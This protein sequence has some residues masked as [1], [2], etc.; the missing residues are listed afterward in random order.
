MRNP[1][2][3]PGAAGLGPQLA[4]ANKDYTA[5]WRAVDT[6]LYDLCRRR[7]NN[8]SFGDVYAKVTIIGR[9]YAAGISR[10]SRASGDAEAEVTRGLISLADLIEQSLQ[11]LAGRQFDRATAARIVELHG[12]VAGGLLPY[13]GDTWQHS[14]V[15]KYLHFHCHL[16]PIYDSN[17]ERAVGGFVD[18][19]DVAPVRALMPDLPDSARAYRNFV[20]AFVVLRERISAETSI[21]AS[22]KEIDHLLWHSA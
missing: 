14:F 4:R 2:G 1:A 21:A 3:T 19:Q 22:V 12:R 6:E 7:S 20:A 11:D 13:T 10:S 9:V 15:S 5:T 8:R 16:V 17:A 18:W